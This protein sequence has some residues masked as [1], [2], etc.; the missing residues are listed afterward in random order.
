MP[1]LLLVLPDRRMPKPFYVKAEPPLLKVSPLNAVPA[2][3]VLLRMAPLI[4]A[5][6]KLRESP[7]SGGA[8]PLGSQLPEVLQLAS[9]PPPIQISLAAEAS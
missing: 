5:A 4:P 9:A 8:L 3:K 7:A 6:P 2:V 1:M